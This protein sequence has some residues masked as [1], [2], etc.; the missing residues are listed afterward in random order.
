MREKSSSIRTRLLL[1][2]SL[3]MIVAAGSMLLVIG[4]SVYQSNL[5]NFINLI[6][7]F[8]ER[9]ANTIEKNMWVVLSS[10]E[11]LGAS[12]SGYESFPS[13]RRIDSCSAILESY[14]QN[15]DY[16]SVWAVYEP[17]VLTRGKTAICWVRNDDDEVVEDVVLDIDGEWY[18]DA[19]SGN[20]E[21][22]DP[23]E[24][25]IDGRSTLLTSAFALIHNSRGD[26]VG[27]CGIDIE[28]SDLEESVDGSSISRDTMCELMTATGTV[29]ASSENI[30]AGSVSSYFSNTALER[31]FDEAA[32]NGTV[33]FRSDDALIT[34]T[35]VYVDHTDNKWFLLARTPYN[36]VTK[37]ARATIRTIIILFFVAILVMV[38]IVVVAVNSITSHL[39][40]SVT[41]FQNIGQGDGDL[42]IRLSA[43]RNDEIGQMYD[44]FNTVM[45][46]LAVSIRGVK[47]ECVTMKKA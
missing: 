9:N 45:E 36:T 12:L 29:L 46:K 31:R 5:D 16:V 2:L 28:L 37:N 18:Q 10:S 23:S 27:L 44:S 39:Q 15:T 41:I 6:Q 47:N 43:S 33:S 4:K 35:P 30:A 7:V 34:I 25:V 38:G 17:G 22:D 8:T 11:S 14:V 40:R 1:S 3:C 21:F 13:D 20:L 24:D 42:T 19:I 32:L 26:I